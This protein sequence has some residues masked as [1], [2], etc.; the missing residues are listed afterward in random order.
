MQHHIELHFVNDFN[1][2]HTN[3]KKKTAH[4]SWGATERLL[5]G[6]AE[7]TEGLLRSLALPIVSGCRVH[8]GA[9]FN[10]R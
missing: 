6:S 9:Q 4:D 7:A 8:C 1:D 10:K 5:F 2:C 3:A